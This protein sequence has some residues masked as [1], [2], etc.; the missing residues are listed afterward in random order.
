MKKDLAGLAALLD[1]V[2]EDV[3]LAVEPGNDTWLADDLFELLSERGA[4][5]C[6][7]DDVKK[8][9][10]LVPTAS[11]GYVRLRRTKYTKA[12]LS[13]WAE[14]L[15]AQP[16]KEAWVFFKHEDEATGPR[17]A[18]AFQRVLDGVR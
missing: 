15:R 1:L 12:A 14:R 2:P 16:W 8:E 13:A 10:P 4:S 3:R 5:L 11:F 7:I 9:I 17:L 18:T 6:T